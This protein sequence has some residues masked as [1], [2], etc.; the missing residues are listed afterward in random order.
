MFRLSYH[1]QPCLPNSKISKYI[2][3]PDW[4]NNVSILNIQEALGFSKRWVD[5]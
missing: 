5:F 1:Q 3:K 4:F 2:P